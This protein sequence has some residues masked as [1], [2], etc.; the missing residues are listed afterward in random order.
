MRPA[1]APWAGQAWESLGGR[2]TSSS[3]TAAPHHLPPLHLI[4]SH[5]HACCCRA[6]P[7]WSVLAPP[8]AHPQW[9]HT[10]LLPPPRRTATRDWDQLQPLA[11]PVGFRNATGEADSSIL[12]AMLWQFFGNQAVSDVAG[13]LAA[14]ALVVPGFNTAARTCPPAPLSMRAL[15]QLLLPPLHCWRRLP[16][17]PLPARRR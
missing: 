8:P 7:S 13:W 4:I 1:P 16:P 17:P 6:G 11:C 10:F 15:S 5:R 9:R 12:W 2:C 3:P 14:G